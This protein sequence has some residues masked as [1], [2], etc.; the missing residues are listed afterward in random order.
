MCQRL[1]P[2]EAIEAIEPDVADY[3]VAD[4]RIPTAE[5][6]E[7]AFEPDEEPPVNCTRCFD[8]GCSNCR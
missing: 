6:I 5:A 7:E 2:R 1:L 4:D 8:A 3:L